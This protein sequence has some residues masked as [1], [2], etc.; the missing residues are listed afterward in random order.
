MTRARLVRKPAPTMETHPVLE[1]RQ[2]FL[3]RDGI[4]ILQGIDWTVRRGEHWVIL[5][6]NG[7]GKTSLLKTL[8]AYQTPSSG[9]LSLLGHIYGACDWREIRPRIGIVSSSLQAS[10]P[11]GEMALETVISGRYAQ[12]DL[13]KEPTKSDVQLARRWLKFLGIKALETRPW[14]F[15]SQGERQRVLI[16]RAMMTKPALLILDEACAGLDPVAREA[17]LNFVETLAKHQ[18][19]PTLVFV[20]HHV[21]EIIPIFTHALLLRSGKVVACGEMRSTLDNA[22]LS[23]CLGAEVRLATRAGRHTL[24]LRY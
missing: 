16:A 17:F 3:R 14:G 6:P 18:D 7:C 13:W 1:L 10:I 2:L 21:E 11:A 22:N 20:T 9:Q 15:L 24:L 23:R 4:D 12:L 19:A 5:G 8:L